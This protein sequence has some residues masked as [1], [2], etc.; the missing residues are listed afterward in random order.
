MIKQFPWEAV[1]LNSKYE[2]EVIAENT[3]KAIPIEMA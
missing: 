3:E 2:G 1:F